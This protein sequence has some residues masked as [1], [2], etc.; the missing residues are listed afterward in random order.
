[1]AR[2]N[3]PLPDDL[4]TDYKLG[5]DQARLNLPYLLGADDPDFFMDVIEFSHEDPA[6]TVYLQRIVGIA[7]IVF[8]VIALLPW[9]MA[10]LIFPLFDIRHASAIGVIGSADGSATVHSICQLLAPK[11]RDT[12]RCTSFVCLM[13]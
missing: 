6:E 3:M 5:F 7:A 11:V 10:L 4:L 12:Q 8:G 13:P 2:A 1:M 9:I